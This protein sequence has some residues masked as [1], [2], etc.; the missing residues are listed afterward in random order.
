ME[1]KIQKKLSIFQ[2]MSFE[3]GVANSHNLER[4]NCH[5][6]SMCQQTPLRFHLTLVETFLE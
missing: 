5:R 3:L 4:D 2:I 6:Q 1:Q